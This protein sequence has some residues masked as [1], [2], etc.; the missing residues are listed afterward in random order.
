MIDLRAENPEREKRQ[1]EQRQKDRQTDKEQQ[2]HRNR[3]VT[4]ITHPA[5][6]GFDGQM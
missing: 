3:D 5:S 4:V 6:R 1:E 2:R